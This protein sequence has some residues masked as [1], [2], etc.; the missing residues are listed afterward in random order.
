M[1]VWSRLGWRQQSR[2][3]DERD[4]LG[5]LHEALKVA[6]TSRRATSPTMSPTTKPRSG[7]T[8]SKVVL[9]PWTNPSSASTRADTTHA[10]CVDRES[11]MNASKPY[12][13]RL[14]AEVLQAD[15]AV[16]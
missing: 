1:T 2:L 12:P 16:D 15:D 13:R 7:L 14:S 4:R 9:P 6:A 5:P 3:L 11:R 8:R 10:S